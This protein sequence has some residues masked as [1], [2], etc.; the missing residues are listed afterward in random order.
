[1]A[2]LFLPSPTPVPPATR[3]KAPTAPPPVVE[4]PTP[5]LVQPTPVPVPVNAVATDNLRVRAAPS[6]SAAIVDHLNKGDTVQI[7][8]RTAANDWWQIALPTKPDARGWIS[9]QFAPAN[10]PVDSIPV[11]GANAPNAPP[12]ANS[13]QPPIVNP[14]PPAFPGSGFPIVPPGGQPFQ[15]PPQPNPYPYR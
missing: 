2:N 9:A 6:T 8:G 14:A 4:L 13:T 10:A 15:P 11:V 5:L 7:L 1:M 12:V 3:T